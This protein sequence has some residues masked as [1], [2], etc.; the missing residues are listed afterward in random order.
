MFI[1]FSSYKSFNATYYVIYILMIPLICWSFQ[2]TTIK[3]ICNNMA[4]RLA[5]P[6]LP[7]HSK[8]RQAEYVKQDKDLATGSGTKTK[9]PSRQIGTNPVLQ[10]DLRNL[11]TK[12]RQKKRT[13]R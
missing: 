12:F 1:Y 13:S 6:S 4:Y 9:Y 11:L 8:V 2:V 7:N 3:K 10:W 5:V